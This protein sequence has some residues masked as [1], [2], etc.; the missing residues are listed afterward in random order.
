MIPFD[1]TLSDEEINAVATY[2]V[3]VLVIPSEGS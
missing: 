1:G 3:H 2:V